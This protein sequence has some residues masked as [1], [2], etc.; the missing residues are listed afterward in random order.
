MEIGNGDLTIQEQRTHFAVWSFMKSPILHGTDV[1][2]SVYFV[3]VCDWDATH[4]VHQLSRLNS[5]QLEIITNA[6]LLAFHQDTTVGAP[7]KPFA[8]TASAPM[9]SPPE[10]YSGLSSKGVHVFIVNT[11]STASKTFDFA[12]VAGLGSGPFKVHDM[13]TSKDL[14]TFTGNFTATLDTHDTA[15]LRITPA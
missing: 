2:T 15:A 1:R 5:T 14:G 3:S 11:N 8:P 6:E 13:W 7:A 10:F 9:T 4:R 12:N